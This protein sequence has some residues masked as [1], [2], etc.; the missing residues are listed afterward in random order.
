ISSFGLAAL[1]ASCALDRMA[2][3]CRFARRGIVPPGADDVGSA[4]SSGQR[5]MQQERPP[6][7][8]IFHLS[9]VIVGLILLCVAVHLVRLHVLTGA[10][11]LGLIA[12]A[13]FVPARYAYSFDIY[14]LVSPASY[15]LL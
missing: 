14:W 12:R 5:L 7:E 13:A 9:G 2:Q 1:A 15:S 8:P 10:Q 3:T 6:R 4:K 11:D